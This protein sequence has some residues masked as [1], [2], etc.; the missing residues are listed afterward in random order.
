MAFAFA[1]AF[2]LKG[3]LNVEAKFI[4]GEGGRRRL[5]LGNVKGHLREVFLTFIGYKCGDDLYYVNY[6]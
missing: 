1:F 5:H 3:E 2:A 4:L 6:L